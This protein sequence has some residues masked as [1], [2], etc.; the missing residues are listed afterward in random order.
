VPH[1]DPKARRVY[2][3]ARY[4]AN[5]EKFLAIT[6][7]YKAANPDKKMT[8]FAWRSYMYHRTYGLT[9]ERLKAMLLEQRGLCAICCK[10]IIGYEYFSS[11]KKRLLCHVDH[12]HNTKAVRRLLCS[13]CN[14]LL[15]KAK[16]DPD[17]LEAAAAYLRS[18]LPATSSPPPS[19]AE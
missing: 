6:K 17:I 7:A 11:G 19:S 4:A 9:I 10:S 1:K 3:A 2:M 18:F 16:D 5:R 14:H 15:G 8:P 13:D 12:D